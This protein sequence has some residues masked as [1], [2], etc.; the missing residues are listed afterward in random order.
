M[1]WFRSDLTALDLGRSLRLYPGPHIVLSIFGPVYVVTSPGPV[2][3]SNL[4]AADLPGYIA[5]LGVP[6]PSGEDLAW[7]SATTKDE[8]CQP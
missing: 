3:R 4:T 2:T 1:T 7:L 5:A 8:Q 6:M